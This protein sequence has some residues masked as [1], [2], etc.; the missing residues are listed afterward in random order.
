MLS[1]IGA[2]VGLTSPRLVR[3]EQVLEILLFQIGQNRGK[4]RSDPGGNVGRSGDVGQG[5][6]EPVDRVV[7]AVHGQPELLEIVRALRPPAAS[8]RPGPREATSR[9]GPR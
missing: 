2:T 4:R 7:V 3:I 9:S 6:R 8:A 5:R 1:V